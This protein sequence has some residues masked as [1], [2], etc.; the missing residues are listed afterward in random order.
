MLAVLNQLDTLVFFIFEF[1]ILWALDEGK[2]VL[3]ICNFPRWH[4]TSGHHENISCDMF[5]AFNAVPHQLECFV[6]ITCLP[7]PVQDSGDTVS[8]KVDGSV[9]ETFSCIQKA[10]TY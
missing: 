1:A 3:P 10:F 8:N 6:N 2:L 7:S 9:A 5:L 4:V